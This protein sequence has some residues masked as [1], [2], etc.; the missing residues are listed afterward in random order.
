MATLAA[1]DRED[2][3]RSPITSVQVVVAYPEQ[4]L[5]ETLHPTPT[6]RREAYASRRNISQ[7][8]S[9]L[10]V[11]LSLFDKRLQ[12]G[13]KLVCYMQHAQGLQGPF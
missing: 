4:Y 11:W 13:N 6:G 9:L 3:W 1:L 5:T 12:T 8:L 7:G 10:T 2:Y